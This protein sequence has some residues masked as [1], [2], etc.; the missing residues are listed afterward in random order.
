MS[1]QE[2]SAYLAGIR[3]SSTI[4]PTPEEAASPFRLELF[5]D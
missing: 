3:L 1:C 2:E 4:S 5:L